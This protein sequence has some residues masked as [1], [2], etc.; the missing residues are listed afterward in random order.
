MNSAM[1]TDGAEGARRASR[2]SRSGRPVLLALAA[3]LT[4]AW[5]AGAAGRQAE[6][7]T[8]IAVPT[9]PRLHPWAEKIAKPGLPNLHR[10][11]AHLYRGAQPTAEGVRE[12]ERMGV[13]TILSLR[14]FHTDKDEAAGSRLRREQ[15]L[16]K[17]WHPEDVDLQRGLRIMTDTNRWPIFVHCQHGA[18][19]TGT[20]IALHRMV[21]EGWSR[22]EAIAEMTQGGFGYHAIWKN[23]IRYL[24]NLDVARL[25]GQ[26]GTPF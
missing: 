25:R 7:G 22:D 24:Q 2:R 15:I 21:V 16:F 10:V 26:L 8:V 11:N 4:L 6:P 17:T 1:A 23:L 14:A 12:L 19:R 20:L 9:G 5:T 13:K 3:G 18:D